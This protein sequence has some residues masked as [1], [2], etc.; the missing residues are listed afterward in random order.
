MHTEKLCLNFS[1]YTKLF[2]ISD[3]ELSGSFHS[4]PDTV[5]DL[6]IDF[7]DSKQACNRHTSNISIA[8]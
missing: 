2:L 4:S 5:A 6:G 1:R 8:A 7:L 3:Y